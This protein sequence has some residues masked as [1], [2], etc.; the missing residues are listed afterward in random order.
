M[1][2]FIV[3]GCGQDLSSD[4]SVESGASESLAYAPEF[5]EAE[6]EDGSNLRQAPDGQATERKLIQ[7][8]MLG[9]EVADVDQAIQEIAR[10]ATSAGGFVAASDIR[11]GREDARSGSV[12]IRIPASAFEGVQSSVTGLGRALS[13]STQSNDVTRE[14]MD[15][16]TRLN[17]KSE[18][19]SRLQA[20][21]TRSGSLEDLLA[22]ER[23]LGRATS[24]LESLKGQL[25]YVESQV[26]L[27]TL[28]I[29]LVEPGAI[30]ARG[31]LRPIAD[32]LHDAV[33]VFAQ[34]IATV[35]YVIVSL[36][37]WLLLA[38]AGWLGV[39]W[40]RRIRAE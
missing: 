12:T 24:E 33:G 18:T 20:L 39:R 1:A 3:G 32:A 22:V 8:G 37:P 14:Y 17:V 29:E 26:S 5:S 38:L 9:V 11:E 6:M 16:E 4:L 40:V 21:L 2:S 15:L 23:E 10:I 13:R 35:I 34:S 36:L 19:V 30:V 31:A 27:S 7:T 28:T 25:Q